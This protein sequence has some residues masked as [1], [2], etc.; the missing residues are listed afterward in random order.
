MNLLGYK[1][2]EI[3]NYWNNWKIRDTVSGKIKLTPEELTAKRRIER[4]ESKIQKSKIKQLAINTPV[5][6]ELHSETGDNKITLIEDKEDIRS[7][8]PTVIVREKFRP[9]PIPEDVQRQIQSIVDLEHLQLMNEEAFFLTFGLGALD[10]TKEEASS[11]GGPLTILEMWKLFCLSSIKEKQ[12][13]KAIKADNPFILSYVVYHHFRSLGWVVR[14]GIKFCTDW[15]LYGSKGPVGGHAEFAVCMIPVFADGTPIKMI[16]DRTSWRWLSTVNRVCAGVKKTLI[17]VYV[18]VPTDVDCDETESPS[19]LT[20]Y[21]V[22][23]MAIKRFIPARM[24]D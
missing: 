4:K 13:D 23:E 5:S 15:V 20:K 21:I 14:S 7:A 12:D 8:P 2:L 11:S 6:T 16:E 19:I 3:K 9:E 10:V 18:I 24:R 1:G 22:K 17:L